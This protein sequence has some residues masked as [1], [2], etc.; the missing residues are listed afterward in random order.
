MYSVIVESNFKA[1]HQLR[2]ADGSVEPLHLHNWLVTAELSSENLNNIGLVIDFN[3]LKTHLQDIT[4]EFVDKNLDQTP[5]FSKTNPSAE[6]VARYIYEKLEQKL[7]KPVHLD[8][9]TV[10]E[11]AGCAGKFR[12]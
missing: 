2:F 6:N 10:V 8:S 4:A 11:Q 9:V 5:Y 1:S 12:R 3:E 7:E